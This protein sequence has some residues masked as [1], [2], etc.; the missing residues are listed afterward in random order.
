MIKLNLISEVLISLTLILICQLSAFAA[1]Y[2][3]TIKDVLRLSDT[4]AF[5][6]HGW[7]ANYLNRKFLVDRDTGKV[8]G[9]TALKARL[10]NYDLDYIPQVLDYGDKSDSFKAITLFEKTG[11]FALLQINTSTE[12]DEKSFFYHTY[13]DM[14]LTGTCTG[15]TS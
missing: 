4:G 15:D 7:S 1:E 3:C 5:V 8:T 2:E 10:V 11:Q 12:D 9:T 6:T 14:I 13:I